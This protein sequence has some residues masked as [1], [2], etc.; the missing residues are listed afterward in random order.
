MG[1]EVK[2]SDQMD[3]GCKS[4]TLTFATKRTEELTAHAGGWPSP[5]FVIVMHVCGGPLP[6]RTPSS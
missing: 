4:K 5:L 6:V 1:E 3:A 2:D